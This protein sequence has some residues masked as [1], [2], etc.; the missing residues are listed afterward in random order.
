MN[1]IFKHAKNLAADLISPDC[2]NWESLYQYFVD[3][4]RDK[5]K[6]LINRE[7]VGANNIYRIHLDLAY[8]AI[9]KS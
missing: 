2:I 7:Y 8:S 1:E 6:D 5:A 4:G 9:I 3:N